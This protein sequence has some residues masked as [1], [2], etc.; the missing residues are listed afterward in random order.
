VA[1]TSQLIN[2][3]N[4]AHRPVVATSTLRAYATRLDLMRRA[5]PTDPERVTR[6]HILD[7]LDGTLAAAT[8][9]SY[10]TAARVFWQ[11]AVDH[12]HIP[13][14]PCRGI[15]RVKTPARRPR[16]LT[17]HEVGLVLAAAVAHSPAYGRACTLMAQEALRIG[18][19]A[20]ARWE[21]TDG[22]EL[23]VR[24]KGYRGELSRTVPLT[25]E[26]RRLL[27]PIMLRGPIVP[28]S[29]SGHWV[30]DRLGIR[31]NELI[32]ATIGGV[33]GDG[34]TGHA[35]RHTAAT[36]MV[37][38]G[39]PLRTVQRILGHQSLATTERYVVGADADMRDAIEGR[40]YLPKDAA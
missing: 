16:H 10:L 3:F 4:R 30:A 39:K 36:D 21:D 20:A 25:I 14:S 11:W 22:L 31:I 2:M 1:T 18:E 34:R 12:D 37:N 33:P 28:N 8:R 6:R 29:R 7:W 13:R 27:R 19:V 23:V 32:R 15:R 9:N 38:R 24:G 5:V 35:L 40:W 26:S 17:P